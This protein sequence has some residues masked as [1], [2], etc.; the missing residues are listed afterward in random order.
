MKD[1]NKIA[2][3]VGE[4]QLKV[5]LKERIDLERRVLF[6]QG[7]YEEISKKKAKELTDSE[8]KYK[9]EHEANIK[10]FRD[11]IDEMNIH[12]TNLQ[13]LIKGYTEGSPVKV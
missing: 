8:K 10:A 2:A 12:I 7:K 1:L 5:Y 4:D 3:E 13:A 6:W 11:K 9:E